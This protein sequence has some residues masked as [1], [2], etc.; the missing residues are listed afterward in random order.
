MKYIPTQ[1]TKIRKDSLTSKCSKNTNFNVGR[2]GPP[3]ISMKMDVGNRDDTMDNFYG[4][5][6]QF[7]EAMGMRLGSKG[8]TEVCLAEEGRNRNELGLVLA[9]IG[10]LLGSYKFALRTHGHNYFNL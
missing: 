2:G 6:S 9:Y 1:H 5:K 10:L 4:T 7:I 8:S 3:R